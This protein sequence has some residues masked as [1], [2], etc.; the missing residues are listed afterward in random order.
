MDFNKQ[1]RWTKGQS[2]TEFCLVCP[3]LIVLCLCLVQLTL[4]GQA[5]F[6]CHYAAHC[7]ARSY[8]VNIQQGQDSARARALLAARA[9]TSHCIPPMTKVRI[10]I[11]YP[12]S[13]GDEAWGTFE[14]QVFQIDLTAAYPLVVPMAGGIFGAGANRGWLNL[15]ASVLMQ[16]EDGKEFQ[17]QHPQNQG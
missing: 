14:R 6:F 16:A 17:D 11:D 10:G 5:I 12:A 15:H 3:L 7:A 4:M 1:D 8:C 9:V 2:L 13:S